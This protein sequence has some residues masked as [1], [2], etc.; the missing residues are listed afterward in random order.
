MG[1]ALLE[2]KERAE[3]AL[4]AIAP[5]TP[6]WVPDEIKALQLIPIVTVNVS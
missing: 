4:Y 5:S 1:L 6:N 2:T 3:F